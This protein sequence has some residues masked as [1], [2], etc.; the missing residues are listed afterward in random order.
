MLYRSLLVGVVILAALA[1]L[2]A[3][4]V[5][6]WPSR[7]IDLTKIRASQGFGY[8]AKLPEP[9][10][11]FAFVPKS[12]FL[13]EDGRG[14]TSVNENGLVRETGMGTFRVGGERVLFSTSDG[15]DPLKNGRRY[16]L[17]I[18]TVVAPKFQPLL[19]IA[20][21]IAAL[22]L[23]WR[24][25]RALGRQ[26]RRA[27]IQTAEGEGVS[28]P[29]S[30]RTLA[31]VLFAGA[32]AIR[33]G[34]LV[35]NPEYTDQ[36]MSIRGIPYSDA[37]DWNRMAKSAAEG[38][39]VDAT[40]PGMRALYPMF[41]AH[42]YT[43][44]GPSLALAKALQAL[45]GAAS[46]ALVFLAL[47]RALPQWPAF[48]A[49]L[50]FAMDPRQVSQAGKLMTEPFGLLLILL[51][52]WCLMIGGDRR[53]PAILFASGTFFACSNLARPLTLFVF[54]I[55]CALIAV[56]AWLC[57]SRRWRAV[58]LHSSAFTLGMAICL[59]SWVVRERVVHGIWGISYNSASALF[60]AST[61]EF[62]TWGA[63]VESRST[64]AGVRHVVKDRYDFFQAQF[65]ENLKK[66]PGFYAGNVARSLRTAALECRNVSPSLTGAWIGAF[67]LACGVAARRGGAWQATVVAVPAL[68]GALALIGANPLWASVFAATGIVFALWWRTFPAAVLVVCHFGALLGSA[69][70]ANPD[71]Q[72]VRLLIDWLEAGWIFAGLFAV[73]SLVLALLMGIPVHVSIHQSS[74]SI[75]D[76][77]DESA[78]LWL[79]RLGWGFATFLVISTCRL[80][81]LNCFAPPARIAPAPLTDEARTAFLQDLAAHAPAW[82]RLTDP[83][84]IAG[85]HGWSRRIFVDFVSIEKEVYH[86]PAGVGS[87]HWSG[88]FSPRPYEYTTFM[89]GAL[90]RSAV[91]NVHAEIAGTIPSSLR[92][93]PCLVIGLIKVRPDLEPYLRNSVET[94]AIIPAPALKPDLT[95]A[96]IAPETPDTRALLDA[97][98]LSH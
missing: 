76:L 92:Q 80:V 61:P 90:G 21:E 82:Q 81:F 9:W 26:V 43:W 60:A 18:E 57:E 89:F 52:A 83:A 39:G 7:T 41:L 31:L 77:A 4:S 8:T 36:Q 70:F 67:A 64:E 33:A 40:Y 28:T 42:F 6:P 78:P 5:L 56:N 71:L 2:C 10:T 12:G 29:V 25:L 15:S 51:S 68:I 32:L 62:G 13:T 3:K 94:V 79:R 93:T 95:R 47:R 37:R 27:A 46:A 55:F 73:I 19:T 16:S 91:P 22:F 74:G 11:G 96:F 38:R 88:H 30:A 45:I 23:L 1:L 84:F 53:R 48:A 17:K 87:E 50:F 44:A 54:P 34:F 69:L 65:R 49:A 75:R 72:R 97:P 58:L 85:P 59:G 86:F 63:G 35:G 24:N 98:V 66:Y 20:G 14:M